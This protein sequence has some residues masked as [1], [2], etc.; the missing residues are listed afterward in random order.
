VS[1][2]KKAF[3]SLQIWSIL[4]CVNTMP[5]KKDTSNYPREATVTTHQSIKAYT[6]IFKQ[7]GV[8]IIHSLVEIIHD[9][10][11]SSPEWT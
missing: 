8:K 11:Q 5:K 3:G 4:V 6:D 2:S 7:S 9:S 1:T 10:C